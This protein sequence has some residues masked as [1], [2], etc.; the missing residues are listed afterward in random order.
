MTWD[1]L[2]YFCFIGDI[3]IYIFVVLVFVSFKSG[4]GLILVDY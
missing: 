3:I 2:F 4:N 1:L